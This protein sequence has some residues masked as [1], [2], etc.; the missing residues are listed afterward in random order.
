MSRVL[1]VF[2]LLLTLSI[3]DLL[4]AQFAPAAGKPGSTA[5]KAD[6][7]CFVGWAVD[8]AVQRGLRQINMPDSGLA[9]V[10]DAANATGPALSKGV[11]SL[12]DGGSAVLTF[13]PPI[14]DGDGYDFA[15]FENAFNDS[16]LE[17]AHVEVSTDSVRWARLP[18]VSQSPILQQTGSFGATLPTRINNL[19]GKYRLPYGT[20]FDLNDIAHISYINPENVRYV[21]IVDVVGSIDSTWGSRD[22]KGNLINDPFPTNFASS[23]FDLDAVGVIHQGP[24]LQILSPKK[25]TPTYWVRYQDNTL[26]LYRSKGNQ[27]GN[28]NLA[29]SE[30]EFSGTE[31]SGAELS[32]RELS[33]A[34]LFRSKLPGNDL[35]AKDLSLVLYSMDGR[36]LAENKRLL[37]DKSEVVW[38]ITLSP[39]IY[40]LRI[41]RQVLRFL[42]P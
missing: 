38:P 41:N 13:D 14:R 36:I 40:T 20:P 19:A 15:V 29:D 9:T 33:G 32:G 1:P 26:F 18:S 28:L 2:G 23:G 10:G 42:V 4:H 3:T 8:C 22:S 39:G 6:S 27:G 25:S 37:A 30:E 11:V 35:S 31:L 16:F 5:I 12:G 21:R 34:E 7:S 17:L 24:T